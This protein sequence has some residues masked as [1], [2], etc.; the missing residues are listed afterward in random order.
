MSLTN[1][2]SGFVGG[3]SVHGM[4]SVGSDI[5]NTTG[6][7]VFIHSVTGSNGNSGLSATEPKATVNG[8]IA[9]MTANKG[10]VGWV[11]PG[12]VEIVTA[13]SMNLSKAGITI[14]NAGNGKTDLPVYTYDA[15]ASEITVSAADVKWVGGYFK[16]NKL[17]VATAFQVD[18]ADG[19]SLIGGKFEDISLILNFLSIVTTTT[20][21][22]AADDLTVVGNFWNSLNTTP[23]AFVSILGDMSHPEISGNTVIAAATNDVGHL[24]TLAAKNVIAMRCYDNILTV[25]STVQTGGVF[26]TGSGTASSGMIARNLV[27]GLDT[28]TALFATAGTKIAFS[29][30]YLSGAADASGTL[31]PAADNPA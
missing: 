9:A 31:F 23:L 14:Y 4:P 3:Y 11:M 24:I 28:T 18:A 27:Q 30:N 13:S 29:E 5:L 17:D 10:D 26:L 2:P 20:T 21:D 6:Q 19:F 7:I 25:A 22:N 8:A 1:F 16:A 15:T 12:H